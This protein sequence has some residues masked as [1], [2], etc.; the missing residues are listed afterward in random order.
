VKRPYTREVFRR[1]LRGLRPV[2]EVSVGADVQPVFRR[3]ETGS[4]TFSLKLPVSYPHLPAFK[5]AGTAA[6]EFKGGRPE[7]GKRRRNSNG[8][9]FQRELFAGARQDQRILIETA[10]RKRGLRDGLVTTYRSGRRSIEF[11]NTP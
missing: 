11:Y 6:A 5:E 9:F 10:G 4:S 3:R 8:R 2:P 7:G 1:R